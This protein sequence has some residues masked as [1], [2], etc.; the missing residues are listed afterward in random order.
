MDEGFKPK[1]LGSIGAY[2]ADIL[3]RSLAREHDGVRPKVIE[4]V[5]RGAVYN[6]ELCADMQLHARGVFL[7]HG[8][9]AHVGDDDRVDA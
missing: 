5:C 4:R 7:S 1:L 2:L 8:D 6:A 3:K 9:D